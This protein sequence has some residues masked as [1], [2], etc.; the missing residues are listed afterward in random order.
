[1]HHQSTKSWLKQLQ[2]AQIR[3]HCSN[4]T[5]GSM[6]L[7]FVSRNTR[8][9]IWPCSYRC[10]YWPQK[11]KTRTDFPHQPRS[12]ACSLTPSILG[13]TLQITH[14]CL[15]LLMKFARQLE[16]SSGWV[17]FIIIE[18][19]IPHLQCLSICAWFWSS[20]ALAVWCSSR[21]LYH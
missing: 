12:R 1:M 10:S 13:K 4:L 11:P 9:V 3:A 6:A 5:Q 20:E 17:S 21:L 19:V 16:R 8:L 15:S 14:E 7:G 2:S 18:I